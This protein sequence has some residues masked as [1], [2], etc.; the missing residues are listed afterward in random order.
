[1]DAELWAEIRRL[2]LRE[3][4]AKKK[5]ARHLRIDPKTV[6]NA[7][8][9]ARYGA[10]RPAAKA[11]TRASKLDPFK[12]TVRSI[13]A[14]YPDLSVERIHEKLRAPQ[15]GYTGGIAVLRRFVWT[16]RPK[17]QAESYLKI[18]FPPGDAAQVDWA[19]CGH[20]VVDGKKRRLSA[21]VFVLCSSRFL[22]VEFT[23]TEQFEVFLACHANALA[24]VQGVPRRVLYD[25]LK[26]VVLARAAGEVRFNPRFV[27]F[28]AHYGFK[29]VACAPY[30]PNEKGRVENAVKYLKRNFLAGRELKDLETANRDLRRW[31]A[32]VANV[33]EHAST[34]KRP[35]DLLEF[36]RPLLAPLP[37]TAYDTRVV[38]TVRASPLC[39]VQFESNLYS[40]PPTHAGRVLTLK[41]STVELVLYAGPDEIARHA[42][43]Q[44]RHQEVVDPDHVRALKE[45][46][47]RGER[48][49]VV[50]CFLAIGDGAEAYLKGLA[51]TEI[52]LYHHVRR[53]LALSDRYG[54]AD[55]HHALLHAAKHGAFGAD[56]VERIVHEERRR[57]RA[58]PPPAQLSLAHAP[59]LAQITLPE[60]DL[61]QYDRALGTGATD[62]EEGPRPRTGG[63]PPAE[64]D[65]AGPDADPRD[66]PRSDH[67]GE[68]GGAL[69]PRDA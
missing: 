42:R 63:S 66:L 41:A 1:M 57:R 53:I 38:K 30:R 34:H 32:E 23:L 44:G 12:D 52:S 47:K 20:V 9:I 24:A 60:I 2:H 13:L 3:K 10:E 46:K 17:K 11:P 67:Q 4:W 56:Y 36:E 43:A 61:D 21:F 58:G 26:T 16:L 8:A 50:Q 5:I 14:A 35:V 62:D 29:P 45:K 51:R 55:V 37:A 65:Q 28:A 22:Y 59:D 39:R 25:N 6:R 19:S 49:A 40:V 18:A 48:G 15:I 31:L 27:D 68:A 7:L 64:P 54:R 69:A 33:R